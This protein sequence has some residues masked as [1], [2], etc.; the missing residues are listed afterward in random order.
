VEVPGV[1]NKVSSLGY[2]FLPRSVIARGSAWSVR[3]R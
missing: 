1:L 3:A 2:R